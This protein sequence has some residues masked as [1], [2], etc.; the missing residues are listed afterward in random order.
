MLIENVSGGGNRLDYGMLAY[1]DVGWMDDRTAPSALVRHNLEGLTLAFPP[2]YLLSFVIDSE[3][4]PIAGASDFEQI[5]RSRMP[6]ILG[7]TYAFQA[8]DDQLSGDL[9]REIDLYKRVRDIVARSHA[10]LLGPQTSVDDDAWDVI[11]ELTDDRRNALIFAFKGA[12]GAA[13][14]RI[15]PLNLIPDVAYRVETLGGSGLGDV[16]GRRLMND[17]VEVA[18]EEDGSHSHVLILSA[19]P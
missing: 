12:G 10:F 11:E 2:A 14:L 1:T 9:R 16:M 4:E 17:G 3:A 8:L 19:L 7:V 13:R 15:R 18:H 6:G 5:A